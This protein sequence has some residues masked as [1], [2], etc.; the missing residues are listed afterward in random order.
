MIK[1]KINQK[2]EQ[3]EKHYETT[4]LMLINEGE[5]DKLIDLLKGAAIIQETI[6]SKLFL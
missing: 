3:R 2:I 5:V 4:V 6:L 1:E